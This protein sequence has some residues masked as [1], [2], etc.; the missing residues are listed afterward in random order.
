[1][2]TLSY[3]EVETTGKLVLWWSSWQ[4]WFFAVFTFTF[5]DYDI[6]IHHLTC[7][8]KYSK[9]VYLWCQLFLF[10]IS[11]LIDCRVISIE[12]AKGRIVEE[13]ISYYRWE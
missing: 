4:H 11:C 6:N 3:F 5:V 9:Y 12:M 10:L 13:K 8:S 2:N 7:I 1:L